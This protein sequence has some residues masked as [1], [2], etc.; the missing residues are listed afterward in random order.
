MEKDQS[1]LKWLKDIYKMNLRLEKGI[2]VPSTCG[3]CNKFRMLTQAGNTVWPQKKKFKRT[4]LSQEMNSLI[5]YQAHMHMMRQ[6]C[7]KQQTLLA[8]VKKKN[9]KEKLKQRRIR[10]NW[11]SKCSLAFSSFQCCLYAGRCWK[12]ISQT[13]FYKADLYFLFESFL[14]CSKK[15]SSSTYTLNILEKDCLSLKACND[16]P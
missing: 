7:I 6:M 15:F 5:Y 13:H 2:F 14:G 16:T 9:Q 3:R 10:E 1:Y 11:I 12:I 4:R 8:K